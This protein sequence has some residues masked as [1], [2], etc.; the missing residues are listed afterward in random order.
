MI[1]EK[2][3]II[4]VSNLNKS[5]KDKKV[6]RKINFKVSRGEIFGIIGPNGAGKTVLLNTLLGLI[7]PDSGQIKIFDMNLE[8]NL[9]TI[10]GRI[11]FASSYTQL[12]P[13]LDIVSNLRVFGKLYNVAEISLKIKYLLSFFEL[14]ELAAS[15]RPLRFFSSGENA[16]VSAIKALLNDPEILFLDEATASLDNQAAQKLINFL[17]KIN[18][19]RKMTIL[20]TTHRLE[21]LKYFGGTVCYLEKGEIKG[22]KRG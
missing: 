20:Y 3:Y 11:N 6:L 7:S 21:E 22:I 8:Q 15:K 9:K 19:K 14:Q 10:R 5:F 13:D 12:P 16:R 17:K 18:K 2:N 4:E 1:K